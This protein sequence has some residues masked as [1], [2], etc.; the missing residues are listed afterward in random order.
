MYFQLFFYDE[1]NLSSTRQCAGD[2]QKVMMLTADTRLILSGCN[3]YVDVA[4]SDF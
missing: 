3:P 4:D 1:M 2:V